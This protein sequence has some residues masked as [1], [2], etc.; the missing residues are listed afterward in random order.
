MS[1]QN[2]A[3]DPVSFHHLPDRLESVQTY[4]FLGFNAKTAADLWQRWS[5]L[6]PGPWDF[7][8][9]AS[10]HI[11]N[12]VGV[13]KSYSHEAQLEAREL[14]GMD[15]KYGEMFMD[16]KLQELLAT[17]STVRWIQEIVHL[18]HRHLLDIQK[19]SRE[20]AQQ[21]SV[22]SEGNEVLRGSGV[23]EQPRAPD[24]SNS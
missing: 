22:P 10:I 24:T 20:R 9:F 6:S 13:E 19:S 11:E 21:R 8:D 15:L 2:A 5:E 7:E 4:E 14:C 1:S 17:E 3:I 16:P 18:R 12:K 23:E